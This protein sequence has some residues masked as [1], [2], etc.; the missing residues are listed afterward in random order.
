MTGQ[1]VVTCHAIMAVSGRFEAARL[2]VRVRQLAG[3][4]GLG[5]L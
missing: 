2:G 3:P 5:C 1:P 4:S